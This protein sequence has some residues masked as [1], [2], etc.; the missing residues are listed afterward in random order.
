MRDIVHDERHLS[1]NHRH[2]RRD[3]QRPPRITDN[4]ERR[5]SRNEPDPDETEPNRVVD[6]TPIH[7][8]R[9]RNPAQQTGV[10]TVGTPPR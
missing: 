1:E 2:E 6:R 9:S 5:P 4:D 3:Q 7:Q 10:I 8:S